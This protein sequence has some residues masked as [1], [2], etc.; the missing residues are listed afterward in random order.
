M[1]PHGG[2]G[3]LEHWFLWSG[4]GGELGRC[5]ERHLGCVLEPSARTPYLD[6]LYQDL[7]EWA[8]QGSNDHLQVLRNRSLNALP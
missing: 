6:Q 1:R 8:E 5:R 2:R 7:R 4:V 3:S